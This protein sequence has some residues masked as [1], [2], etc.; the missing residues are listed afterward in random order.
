[1][2][3][4]VLI[5]HVKHVCKTALNGN[6]IAV[7]WHA[8]AFDDKLHLMR[9]SALT[10]VFDLCV[11]GFTNIEGQVWQL[12]EQKCR[13]GEPGIY[14]YLRKLAEGQPTA[15]KRPR[16]AAEWKAW[17]IQFLMERG[18]PLET[19]GRRLEAQHG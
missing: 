13:D 19:N 1:M 15:Q 4:E 11:G 17:Q 14:V 6:G 8:P 18:I 7:L 5:E 12:F 16:T 2:T 3:E 9:L 10:R